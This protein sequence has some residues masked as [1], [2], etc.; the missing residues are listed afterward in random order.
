[1]STTEKVYAVRPNKT[2]N[3][4][5]MRMLNELGQ[6]LIDLPSTALDKM[7]M[8]PV[9][10]AAIDEGKR[11]SR[12]AL[13]RQLRRIASLLLREDS[14]T[15]SL[16][17]QRHLKPDRETNALFHKLETW[18]DRLIGG[19]EKLLSE[20]LDEYPTVDRQ[21]FRQL[22]RNAIAERKTNK[23]PK[24]YRALF[25]YLRSLSDQESS[26]LSTDEASESSYNETIG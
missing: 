10:R 11:L 7:V 23:P 26:D 17:V 20:I 25:K 14:K 1:M 8:L 5:E 24:F 12:G 3:K 21:H 19:D 6:Q 13:Q 9:T 22:I 15:L 4:R 16:E 2:Q 18:R